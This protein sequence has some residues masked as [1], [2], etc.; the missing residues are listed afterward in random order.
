MRDGEKIHFADAKGLSLFRSNCLRMM[1]KN[2][3]DKLRLN[4]M[5]L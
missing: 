3:V 4:A 1:G 2:D 5:V